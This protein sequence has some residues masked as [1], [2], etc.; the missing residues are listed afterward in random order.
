MSRIFFLFLL[1]SQLSHSQSTTL[2]GTVSDTLNTPLEFANVLAK[3]LQENATIKFATANANGQYKMELDASARYEISVS[4]IGYKSA[5]FILEPASGITR[6]DF[7]LTSTGE[8]L[9]EVIIKHE[10]IV[11]KKDT[12][13]F[14]VRSFANGNERKMKE[15]LE[16]LPGVEVDKN[17]NVSVQ[18]KRVTQ[19]LVEGQSF[20][21]GGSKLAVENIPADALDKIE[22]IDHFN[23]VGFMKEVSDSD[24]LAMNV[25]LKE[26]KKKFLFG[27]IEAG[28][29][30]DAYYLAHAALFYYSPKTSLSAIADLNNFGQSTFTSDDLSR[31]DGGV[32]SFLD[33][34]PSLTNLYSYANDNTDLVENKSQFGALNYNIAASEKLRVSGYGLFSKTALL[35]KSQTFNQ[36]LQNDELTFERLSQQSQR[37]SLLALG[38]IKLDYSRGPEEKWYYNAQYQFGNSRDQGNLASVSDSQSNFFSNNS[39]T[40]ES[41]LKQYLEWHKRHSET[42][43]TTFVLNHA[44]TKSRPDTQW[45]AAQEFLAGLLPLEPDSA[46]A[47]HQGKSITDNS[48]DAVFKQ[49]FILNKSNHL[50]LHLGNNHGST[51][52]ETNESQILSDGTVNSF[53]EA[54]F[55][56]DVHYRLND[57]YAGLEYKFR[58]GKWT[59]KPGLYYHWYNLKVTQPDGNSGV[60]KALFEPQFTSEYEFSGSSNLKLN[61][62]LTNDFARADQYASRFTLQD[63]NLVFRGNGLLQNQRFHNVNLF[64]YKNNFTKGVDYNFMA[65]FVWNVKTIRNQVALEGI[66]QFNRPVLTSNPE[67]NWRFSGGFG[68]RIYKFTARIRASVSGLNYFQTL[69]GVTQENTRNTQNLGFQLRTSHRKWPVFA[70]GYTKNLSQFRGLSQSDFQYDAVTADADLSFLKNFTFTAEYEYRD[71]RD[72]RGVHN[73]FDFLDVSLRYQKK[74]SPFLFSIRANNV[75]DRSQKQAYSFSDYLISETTTFVLPRVVLFSLSYKL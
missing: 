64:F 53:D 41:A 62:K 56:N 50:Y 26:D 10:P 37:K 68:Q 34:R 9:K 74:D 11:I 22:V 24:E 63:Y 32:S 39:D 55:G 40:D 36:Y 28:I 3:P 73:S 18:G 52:Y 42:Y 23:E 17:G 48:I 51:K 66:N 5:S 65:T 29:G 58:I 6:H 71:N 31:F 15:V 38:N 20:F 12:L 1:F 4:Y 33:S 57:A 2:E 30:T 43:T 14:D 25:K 59:N 7:K 16:K 44:Y 54:G 35:A 13:I 72:N 61:Y 45:F 75:F 69:N 67:T 60:S 46:Y 27:D 8:I 21:G 49:Y 70:V 47:I 19:M